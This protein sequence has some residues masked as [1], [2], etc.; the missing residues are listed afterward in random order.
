MLDQISKSLIKIIIFSVLYE[1][2]PG[3]LV[4][5]VIA[6]SPILPAYLPGSVIMICLL[7]ILGVFFHS[8]RQRRSFRMIAEY[9]DH[10]VPITRNILTVGEWGFLWA[11]AM[12]LATYFPVKFLPAV[13]VLTSLSWILGIVTSAIW[14][15]SFETLRMVTTAYFVLNSGILTCYAMNSILLPFD[16]LKDVRVASSADLPLDERINLWRGLFLLGSRSSR[17]LIVLKWKPKPSLLEDLVPD[18]YL[19]PT[20]P[21]TFCR[22]IQNRLRSPA[23]S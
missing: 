16:Q 13:H 23:F 10:P 22:V 11:I 4:G 7:I 21:S 17:P 20:D 1:A 8:V 15:F 5:L 2:V 3:S 14:F 18:I 9:S 12:G 19:T 6:I